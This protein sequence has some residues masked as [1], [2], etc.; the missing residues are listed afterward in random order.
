MLCKYFRHIDLEAVYEDMEAFSMHET[1]NLSNIPYQFTETLQ[2]IFEDLAY[3]VYQDDDA[4]KK[5]EPIDL[6]AEVSDILEQDL[7]HIATIAQIKI[8]GQKSSSNTVIN[9]LTTL[10]IHASFSELDYWQ[11]NS[12]LAYQYDTL[13]W[14][15]S[16][17][18]ITE[19]FEVYELLLKTYGELSAI[20]ALEAS[21][22]QQ[23]RTASNI[24]RERA[25]K[26]HAPS[27]KKK[28]EL[29]DEWTKTSAE[30]KS[31]SDFCRIVGRRAGVK[32]RTLYEWIQA[33]E[34]GRL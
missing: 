34:R 14:L 32:E 33:Y 16:N 6:A 20:Y 28:T 2:T 3:V 22:D 7:E 30:Y 8:P 19:S 12:L 25:Q 31:R 23:N 15:Y 4:W 29:L 27:N 1:T 26:R 5:L 13:C 24:A 17:E 21:L 11:K 9:K 18:K 10:S